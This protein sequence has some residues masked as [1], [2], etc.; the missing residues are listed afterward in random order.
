MGFWFLAVI[1]FAI[2]AT[3]LRTDP[4]IQR[5]YLAPFGQAETPKGASL[6]EEV[7]I[8]DL[9]QTQQKEDQ[10]SFGSA[11]IAPFLELG[12]G[13]V[14]CAKSSEYDVVLQRL[15]SAELPDFAKLQAMQAA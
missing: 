13:P 12:R 5:A 14:C 11:S 15:R 2:S 9:W 8:S 4:Q 6:T 3:L 1:I 7:Q 10:V